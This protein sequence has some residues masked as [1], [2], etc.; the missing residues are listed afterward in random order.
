MALIKALIYLEMLIRLTPEQVNKGWHLF[1]TM[2]MDSLEQ[3]GENYKL[4]ETNILRAILTEEAQAWVYDLGENDISA[5]LLTKVEDDRLMGYRNLV[6]YS[7]YRIKEMSIEEWKKGLE[8]LHR[9]KDSIGAVSIIGYYETED[10]IYRRFLQSL[11]GDPSISI[12]RF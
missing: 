2:I 11:G 4:I 9:Y 3:S 1:G 7:L 12:I 10:K 8:A 6:I 5:F